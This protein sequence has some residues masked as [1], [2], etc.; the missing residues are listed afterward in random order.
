MISHVFHEI[1]EPTQPCSN[2]IDEQ[3][4]QSCRFEKANTSV[5]KKECPEYTNI[6]TH[7]I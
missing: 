3:K 5:M 4:Y 1:P 6:A 2:I 7:A